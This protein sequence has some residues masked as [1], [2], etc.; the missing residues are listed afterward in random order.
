MGADEAGTVT[1]ALVDLVDR[2]HEHTHGHH[3]QVRARHA[4]GGGE[5]C[6]FSLHLSH[7]ISGYEEA[8][9]FA[10]II[11]GK[12]ADPD[13]VRPVVDRWMTEL[14]PSATG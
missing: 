7:S 2:Y 8:C 5:V 10:Q 11:R 12:V 13:A 9:V 6:P 3:V 4:V 14:G 1:K